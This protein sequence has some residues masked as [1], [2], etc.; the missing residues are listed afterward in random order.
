MEISV[1]VPEDK[2]EEWAKIQEQLMMEA[3]GYIIQDIPMTADATI[4]KMWSK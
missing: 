2:A 4:S 1:E 3:G